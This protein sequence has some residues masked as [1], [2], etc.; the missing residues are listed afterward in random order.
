M[1]IYINTTHIYVYINLYWERG[2]V[3]I[4]EGV[5]TKA[6]SHVHEG[7]TTKA[8]PQVLDPN[9]PQQP[10]CTRAARCSRLSGYGTAHHCA[11]AS[12]VAAGW[13]QRLGASGGNAASSIRARG[14]GQGG[15]AGARGHHV[16]GSN[17]RRVSMP[18]L[19][20][21]ALSDNAQPAQFS[22]LAV[23]VMLLPTSTMY[24]NSQAEAKFHVEN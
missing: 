1:Y 2:C 14:G 6:S 16:H 15:L 21:S 3:C 13:Q 23:D 7:L 12:V 20:V 8:S 17:M 9:Q 5:A 22:V 19:A 18:L 24:L 11:A 4:H 10:C